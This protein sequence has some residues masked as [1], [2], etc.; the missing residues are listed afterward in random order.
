MTQV[1]D[2][3]KEEAMTSVERILTAMELK[4]TD[5]VPVWPLIDFLPVKYTDITAEEMLMDPDKSQKAYEWMYNKLGGYDIS[6]PGGGM[7]MQYFNS[8]PDFFSAYYLDWRLPGRQLGE[9]QGPQLFEQAHGEGILTVDDY[10]KIIDEGMLWLANFKRA[11]MRDLMKTPKVAEKVALN[12]KKWW[13]EFKVPTFTDSACSP[14]FELLSMFRGSTNF[15]KDIYRHPEKIKRTCDFLVDKL[16]AMAEYGP[17]Q[18]DGKTILIGAVRSSADFVSKKHF[19]EF[20][21]P[22]LKKMVKRI[23]NDGFIVQLHFDTR[24]TDRLDLLKELPKGRIYLH[25][26]ERTDIVKAKEILGDHMCIEGNIKPSLFTLG[27]PK[28]IV[29]ETKA[30]IDACAEGGGLMVGS[31]IPD[32]AKLENVKAM[33]DTC[34]TYGQY[35]K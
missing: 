15:M 1:F 29:K 2:N 34:K 22:Y 21:L 23:L 9:N 10:D 4:E 20:M 17:S 12:T 30:I 11:K 6:M 3:V 25:M 26:D 13:E 19:E 35:R 24:W 31:E 16:I 27:T 8:F 5:R 32:D 28:Q 7:F 33:I 14:P 18:A